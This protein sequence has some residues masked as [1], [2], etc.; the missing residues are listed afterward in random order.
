MLH[1]G[2]KS[3]SN[4][5][6]IRKGV[7]SYGSRR[8]S[9]GGN[10]GAN[11]ILERRALAGTARRTGQQKPNGSGGILKAVLPS[12]ARHGGQG[13]GGSLT[14]SARRLARSYKVPLPKVRRRPVDRSSSFD[15]KPGSGLLR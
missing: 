15:F 2:G 14:Q 11:H 1:F 3:D 12:S 5:E 7:P 9:S 13:K 6:S 8:R 10:L 4:R